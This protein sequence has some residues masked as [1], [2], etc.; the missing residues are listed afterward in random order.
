MFRIFRQITDRIVVKVL[1]LA[2]ARVDAE[3][4]MEL[5][6]ARAELLAH[7]DEL[8]RSG[9]EGCD[10]LASRLRSRATSLGMEKG[11]PAAEAVEVKLLLADEDLRATE[12]RPGLPQA[13]SENTNL[14]ASG[15]PRQKRRGR[16]RKNS[17]ES[18]AA[19]ESER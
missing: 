1:L 19:E 4:E 14:I 8:E 15:E 6:D 3:V 16:P 12:R 13:N 2:G 7:A 11:G 5:S 10:E 9:V 17:A 18:P